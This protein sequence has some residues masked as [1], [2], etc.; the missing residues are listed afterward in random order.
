MAAGAIQTIVVCI[1]STG[2]GDPALRSL[3]PGV[4]SQAYDPS[5][6]QA[7]VLDPGQQSN[8]DAAVGPFDYEYAGGL[9][10]FAFTMVVGLYAAA[11]GIGSV[12]DFI[13]RG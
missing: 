4:G 8:I 10:A 6:I 7:Y 11:K 9:W 12:L 3:C 2:S 1:P 13:R 5:T